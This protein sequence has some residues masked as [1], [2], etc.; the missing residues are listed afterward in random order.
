MGAGG[1]ESGQ[2]D[3][4][5]FSRVGSPHYSPDYCCMPDARLC[6]VAAGERSSYE[7]DCEKMT[8]EERSARCILW[9]PGCHFCR[10]H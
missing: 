5:A 7:E 9:S 6:E 8:T 2:D 4:E 1:E 3:L 10:L